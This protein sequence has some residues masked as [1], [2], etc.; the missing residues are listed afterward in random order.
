MKNPFQLGYYLAIRSIKRTGFVSKLFII[1]IMM[2]TFLNLLVVRGVLVGIPDS[3]LENVRNDETGDVLIS[4][5]DGELEIEKTFQILNYLD[6]SPYVE[7]Y[8]VRYQTNSTIESDYKVS[9]KDG[10]GGGSKRPVILKGINPTDEETITGFSGFITEGRMIRE[11]ETGS[12]VLGRGLLATDDNPNFTG[13]DLLQ[14]VVIDEGVLVTVNGFTKEFRVVGILA[15]KGGLTENQG[16]ISDSELRSMVGASN[17]NA[18]DIAIRTVDPKLDSVLA[19]DLRSA[20]FADEAKF[21]TSLEAAGEF[22]TDI[23]TIFDFLSGFVG[24]IGIF[25]SGIT[26][27]IIIFVNAVSRRQEI[28][29]TR[30]VGIPQSVII[31]SYFIQAVFYAISGIVAALLVFFFL[32]VPYFRANPLDFPFTDVY[33]SVDLFVIWVQAMILLGAGGLAGFIPARMI[34]K[35]D[36][37]SLILGR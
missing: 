29:I 5:L 30:A 31:S 17:P 34:I 19:Q 3:S 9:K 33:L 10:A 24:I 13:D 35:Q 27:F 4:K 25:I 26:I 8:S 14:N 22:L 1:F 15:S 28:G 23:K 2:L 37:L 12:I 18:S 16:F 6:N 21:E 7:A 32:L 36:V 20:S 11:G